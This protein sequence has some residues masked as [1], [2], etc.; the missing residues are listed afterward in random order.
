MKS[1]PNL[2][3]LPRCAKTL[4]SPLFLSIFLFVDLTL[5][6]SLDLSCSAKS[7]IEEEENMSKHHGKLR[8]VNRIFVES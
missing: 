4:Y 8:I 7:E 2:A 3:L 5:S 1:D 6:F